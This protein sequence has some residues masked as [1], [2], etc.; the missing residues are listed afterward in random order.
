MDTLIEILTGLALGIFSGSTLWYL[1]FYIPSQARK[2][3]EAILKYNR[4][5][6]R[7]NGYHKGILGK[8]WD[9]ERNGK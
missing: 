8:T 6:E 4:M 5:I 9:D 3:R 2:E 1:W 7:I